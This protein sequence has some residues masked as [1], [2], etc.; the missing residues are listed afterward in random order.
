MSTKVLARVNGIAIQ[1]I[2]DQKEKLIPI[3]P[4]CEAL[5]IDESAQRRKL[6]ED[7]FL[8]SVTVLSTATGSD[9]KQYEMVCLPHEFIFGWLFTINP[10][11][12]QLTLF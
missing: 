8:S 2:E 4:I 3:R 10:K 9:G 7:D 6:Q 12:N 5:G 1:A 11:N